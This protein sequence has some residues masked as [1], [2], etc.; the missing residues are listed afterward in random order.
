MWW[1]RYECDAGDGVTSLGDNLI[2]LKSRQLA[3]FARFCSL[4]H[5][6]LYFFGI[7]QILGG[8]AETARSYLLGL[9]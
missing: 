2:H 5:L 7:H 4:S 9:R 8:N 3:S 1:R 6:D